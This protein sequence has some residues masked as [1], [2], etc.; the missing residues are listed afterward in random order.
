MP[1]GGTAFFGMNQHPRITTNYLNQLGRKGDPGPGLNVGGEID[2][3]NGGQKGISGMIAQPY[4]G[5]IGGKLTITNPW[6]KQFEDPT[7]GPLYGGI[8]QYVRFNPTDTAILPARGLVAFWL[9]ELNYVVTTN[10][11]PTP[12]NKIAGVMLNS[13]TP[14]NWDFIQIAGIAMV[15]FN[16]AVPLGQ[17][18]GGAS[19]QGLPGA[20]GSPSTLGFTVMTAGVLGQVSPVE[21]NLVVGYNF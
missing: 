6:A 15:M 4:A 16:T 11:G 5:F 10:P 17:V 20:A 2:T 9:D 14:G 13:T 21:L 19:G 1:I 12:P 3:V 8:Y 18:V 7:V